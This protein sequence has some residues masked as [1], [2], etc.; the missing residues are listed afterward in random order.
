MRTTIIDE[1]AARVATL[2]R[3][4][5]GAGTKVQVG[6]RWSA[7]SERLLADPPNLVI[8]AMDMLAVEG[9]HTLIEISA[10]LAS[11]PCKTVLVYEEADEADLDNVRA[12]L[13]FDLFMLWPQEEPGELLDQLIPG[14]AFASAFEVTMRVNAV[15]QLDPAERLEWGEL[16]AAVP[17]SQAAVIF[18][19]DEALTP[20]DR[21]IV[22]IPSLSQGSL[23]TLSPVRLL[24]LLGVQQRTGILTL[25]SEGHTLRMA[26]DQGRPLVVDH[27][28]L[29]LT[30]FHRGL[31]WSEGDYAFEERKPIPG[32][33]VSARAYALGGMQRVLTANVL[34]RR[35]ATHEQHVPVFTTVFESQLHDFANLGGVARFIRHCNGTRTLAQLITLYGE[36]ANGMLLALAFALDTDAVVMFTGETQAPVGVSYG[37]LHS[38]RDL[39][40]R[41]TEPSRPFLDIA[42]YAIAASTLQRSATARQ[43]MALE[44]RSRTRL[45]QIDPTL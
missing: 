15:S 44:P 34:R 43:I 35:F 11:L 28:K 4:L 13:D 14:I 7:V 3:P 16:F 26:I 19:K 22:K 9:F 36:R 37:L 30:D 38:S 23:S 33:P 21:V 12:V 32:K 5:E 27:P 39:E 2:M 10:Q 25:S 17:G 42:R 1:N 18:D 29:Q 6:T 8:V 24:F 20:V 40:E 31:D 45:Q 41:T